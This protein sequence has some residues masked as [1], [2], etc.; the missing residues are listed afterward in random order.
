MGVMVVQKREAVGGGQGEKG[1]SGIFLMKFAG[2]RD[3]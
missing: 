3:L 2:E 1:K